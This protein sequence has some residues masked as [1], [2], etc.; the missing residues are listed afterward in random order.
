MAQGSKS[1]GKK[2]RLRTRV[3]AMALR[4]LKFGRK[5]VG[6]ITKFIIYSFLFLLAFI[7]LVQIPPVQNYLIDK[8]TRYLSD[9]LKTQVRIEKFSLN[10]F[11]EVSLHGVF[12]GNENKPEDTLLSIGRLR[13]DINYA[14]F[15]WGITQLDAIKLEKTVVRMRQDSGNYNNNLQFIADYFNPPSDK[16]GPPKPTP[17]VRIGQIHLRDIDFSSDDKVHGKKIKVLLKAADVHSNIIN[18]PKKLIDITRINM[19]EP[20]F[21]ITENVRKPLPPKPPKNLKDSVL[22]GKVA[23]ASEPQT[24]PDLESKR[25]EK[26]FLCIIGS[27]SVE[28]GAFDIDNWRRAP[29]RLQPDTLMDYDHWHLRNLDVS[30]HNFIYTKGEYT[31]TVDGIRFTDNTGFVLNKL[32]VGDAKISSTETALYGLQIETPNSM[33]GDTF[34]MVYDGYEAFQNFN[35]AV[36]LDARIHGS[37]ILIDDII[38]FAPVLEKNAFFRKNRRENARIDGVVG[39]TINSLKV[40]PFDIQLA[41]GIEARGTFESKDLTDANETFMKLDL[42]KLQ[43]SITALRELIPNFTP[44]K[45]FDRLGKI[46]F[47]GGFVG[48]YNNISAGGELESAI[49]TASLKDIALEIPVAKGGTLS[50]KGKINLMNFDVAAF[51]GNP[52][53]GKLS[54]AANIKKGSGLKKDDVNI[55]LEASIKN[56]DFKKYA[57]RDVQIEG[58]IAKNLFDGKLESKDPNA[59][60]NFDGEI[61]FSSSIPI[62]KF[63]SD[64]AKLDLKNLNLSSQDIALTGKLKLDLYGSRL[65]E[66]TGS[67]DA[68]DI[69]I[70]KDKTQ[71]HKIDSL[72]LRADISTADNLRTVSLRSE[73]LT[74]DL[75]GLFNIEQLGDAFLSQFSRFHPRLAADLKLIPK[76]TPSF[77]HNFSANL[78]ILNTKSLTK[79]FHEKLDTLRDLEIITHLNDYENTFDWSID[80]RENIRFGDIKIVEFG[81]VGSSKGTFLDWDLNTYNVVIGKDQDFKNLTFQNQIQ[82][83]TV[84]FGFTSPNFSQKLRMDKVELN[85]RLMRQDTAYRLSFLTNALSRLRIFGDFWDI[86]PTNSIVFNS[87]SIKIQDFG[88]YNRDRAIVFESVG[89]RGLKAYLNNFNLSFLDTFIVDNR[90]KMRGRYRVAAEFG[91][92]FKQED[93]KAN[94]EV[95]DSFTVGLENRGMLNIAVQGKNLNSPLACELNLNKSESALKI[96]GNYFPKATLDFPENALDLKVDLSKFPFKTLQMIIENGASDFTGQVEGSVKVSGPVKKLDYNGTLRLK[97]AGI[98]IDYLKTRLL[99]RDEPVRITSNEITVDNGSVYDVAGRRAVV[100]G[101][102]L[103]NNFNNFRLR[104]NI[105]ADTFLCLNTTRADNPL[106][107]GTGVGS[108]D[109][110]FGGDFKR[111]DIRIRAVAGKG[112]KITFPFAAEKNATNTKYVVF[113]NRNLNTDSTNLRTKPSFKEPSGI[114]LDMELSLTD[115]AEVNL[116]FNEEAGDNI[117]A[118]GTGDF[119]IAIPRSGGLLMDGE[120]R[121]EKG[122][123]LFTLLKLVTKKFNI[124]RGSTIRWNGTP[125]DATINMNAEYRGLSTAPYNFIAEY[126][127]SDESTRAECRKPTPVELTMNLTSALLKPDINF[128]INFPR[129]AGIAKT[130]TENRLR[131]LR[132]DPNELNRQVFGLIVVGGFL[133]SDVAILGN[134]QLRSGGLNTAFETAGSVLSSMF[135]RLIS[136]YVSGLDVEIGYSNYQ[137][138][139]VEGGDIG[140]NG[141]QFRARASYAIDDRTTFTAGLGVESGGF[142]AASASNSLFLGTDVLVD[143]AIS[144]DRRL[145]LRISYSRDQVV[146]G[147]RDKPAIGLRYRQEFDTFEELLEN[148]KLKR[149][150][151]AAVPVP[152]GSEGGF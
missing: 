45:E 130:Y 100:R 97:E 136:E 92:I 129:L 47:V 96:A 68:Y 86:S 117:R 132:Q 75:N 70:L 101:G 2:P 5:L 143:Y 138:D 118:N 52:D 83:D 128:D 18:L 72:I 150:I 11:D 78:K 59:Q 54:I 41:N 65:N 122:D 30:L 135:S 91:D 114:S 1:A 33:V 137:F 17:D 147:R 63:N 124:K 69:Q 13:A 107:Y 152:N 79:L 116:I 85:A 144:A 9:E 76:K 20:Q 115:Q 145:K 146:E 61:D 74:L 149:K 28:N 35:D 95:V 87:N 77:P 88:L 19:Y 31:G 113:T 23:V 38:T 49:G 40:R 110:T 64:V 34:R 43:T 98:T 71:R 131:V 12:I 119:H 27:I 29:K 142:A 22:M 16:K 121:I 36:V 15:A 44:P 127:V 93:L 140:K 108:G 84:E 32:T 46:G 148:L 51:T 139:N 53:F 50:Y 126:L 6:F 133:P 58:N 112:T 111:T 4:R 80:T 37:K 25:P 3:R 48:F 134:N 73:I 67:I 57:Y 55:D 102:L 109:I 104:V 24:T 39:G 94:L 21:S 141:S 103:H 106:F 42:Q 89:S 123:Y 81:S 105:K 7:A 151:A 82:G 125:F 90:F 62:Y 10:F 8:T 14:D 56:F 120:Y 66:I 26:P 99:V 60:L